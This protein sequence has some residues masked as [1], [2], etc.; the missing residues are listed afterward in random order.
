MIISRLK[1]FISDILTNNFF[2]ILADTESG[3]HCGGALI[4]REYVL[5]ASHCVVGKDLDAHDWQL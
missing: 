2:H 5:T 1:K 3:F 4:S